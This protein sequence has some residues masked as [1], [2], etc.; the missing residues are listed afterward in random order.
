MNNDMVATLSNDTDWQKLI[1][2]F[3][4]T[5]SGVFEV[6]ALAEY[7]AADATV[8]VDTMLVVQE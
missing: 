4:P 1:I 3:T 2:E 7:V 8:Y 6:E 5:E